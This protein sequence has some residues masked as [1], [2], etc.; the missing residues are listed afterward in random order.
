MPRDEFVYPLRAFVQH[1]GASQL[2]LARL[3]AYSPRALLRPSL[4]LEQI[5]A[6][7]SMSLLIIM[8]CGL[9]VGMVLGLQG[10]DSLSRFGAED[11][12][13]AVAALSL[14]RELGP[15]VTALLFSGRAGTALASEIG[16]MRATDQI[17][18][19]E[20]MAIDPI[21]R[22]AVPRFIGATISMPLLAAIFSAIGIFGAWLVGV[23]LMRV[24]EGAF[25]GSIRQQVDLYHDV[26]SGIVKSM[27]FGGV[28]SFLAVFEGY[29]SI[30]TAEGVSRATTRTVVHT[31]IAV[32]VLDFVL[33]AL[34]LNKDS[35]A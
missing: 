22:I 21:R 17:S 26:V 5:H 24:D 33:T 34:F 19:L 14:L 4:I 11:S 16:L 35:M 32:L 20:M 1:F 10:F 31:A 29:N 25:W 15:V 13:G 12:L 9:F 23:Q 8:I 7:G 18:A 2:F 28:A 3:I 27:V 6:T 30:P